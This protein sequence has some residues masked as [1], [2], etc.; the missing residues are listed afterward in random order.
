MNAIGCDLSR[1]DVSFDPQLA[2][3]PIDFAFQKATEGMSYVDSK[4][5]EIWQ[6]VKQIP[7]RG[8]YHYQLS[9]LSW[10]A[11]A[12]HFLEITAKHD[13]HIY[14]LDVE[15]YGNTYT[16]TY[17]A[18][19]KRVVDYWR[20]NAN[21][22]ILIYTNGS[23]YTQMYLAMAR[24]YGATYTANWMNGVDLW[25]ASPTTAG[26]P[27]LPKG[28]EKWT[29]H[30]YSW[31]GLPSRWG[32][33]G[34]RVDENVFNGDLPALYQWLEMEA[35]SPIE[36][37]T[38]T[39]EIIMQGT[40]KAFTNIRASYNKNSTDLGDLLTGDIVT[41][42]EEWAGTDGLTW[43]K[44]ITA[45]RNG[46]PVLCTD[47]SSVAGK[48]AWKNNIAEIVTPPATDG[49]S[50]TFDGTFTLTAPDGKKYATHIV[51][52]VPLDPQ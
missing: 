6:G 48:Y 10:I 49:Y 11:Q 42:S 15:E 32:T 52:D 4:Y 23:T 39:E 45:T 31:G 33:G 1:Y 13:Y 46:A 47:G 43:I 51:W 9:G 34:T 5:E 7:V 16:D 20:K 26:A 41:W 50:A 35:P 18:D 12:D 27:W 25:I 21:K 30:Q 28:R 14:A 17:F 24:L 19:C 3:G 22:K 44:L 36:P 40:I 38:E 8:A 2:T 29:F 37:P